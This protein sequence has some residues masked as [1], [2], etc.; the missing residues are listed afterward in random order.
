MI[1]QDEALKIH[2]ILIDKYGGVRGVRDIS[3]L[4]SALNRPFAS[5]NKTD[6]YPTEID[7]AAAII[8]SII[9]N[10]PFIDGNKRTGYVLMRLFLLENSYDINATQEEKYD[11]VVNIAAGKY[12]IEDIKLWLKKHTVKI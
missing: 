7:K 1:K 5:F 2:E 9:Q 3:A 10:H 11:F 6:L 4:N 12:S 8:E